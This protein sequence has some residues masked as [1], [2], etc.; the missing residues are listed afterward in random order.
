MNN[1]FEY[2]NNTLSTIINMA[3]NGEIFE[4]AKHFISMMGGKDINY[5]F[6]FICD[7]ILLDDLQYSILAYNILNQKTEFITNHIPNE[8]VYAISFDITNDKIILDGI[9]HDHIL[10]II[11]KND[12][13]HIFLPVLYAC[14][15]EN[16][17]HFGLLALYKKTKCAYLV[18][19]NGKPTYFDNILAMDISSMI[20]DLLVNY[21]ESID[22]TFVKSSVWNKN[23]IYLNKNFGDVGI[24][25]GNCMILGIMMCNMIYITD[26]DPNE[27]FQIFNKLS[28]HELAYF[29]K[30]YSIGMYNV[31]EFDGRCKSKLY[32]MYE[33][34]K[35]MIPECKFNDFQ[36]MVNDI[37]KENPETYMDVLGNLVAVA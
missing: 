2:I 18:D 17:G 4:R 27:L 31:L 37:K 33:L 29:I 24:E 8:Q 21:F 6:N 15:A 7:Q 25:S 12:A 1:N 11:E 22:Y 16:S 20:E 10:K 26:I 9:S 32:D 35:Q 13:D 14:D 28:S 34:Y 5:V 30:Q 36:M 19:P 3:S 23:K